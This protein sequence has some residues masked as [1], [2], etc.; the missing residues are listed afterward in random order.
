MAGPGKEGV[1]FTPD[2]SSELI[3][4]FLHGD[5]SIPP[6]FAIVKS[7]GEMI[8]KDEVLDCPPRRTPHT[9]RKTTEPPLNKFLSPAVR[10]PT[11]NAGN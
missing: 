11:S 9:E 1:S 8:L 10:M 5:Q 4:R 7:G 6:D 2:E 3:V